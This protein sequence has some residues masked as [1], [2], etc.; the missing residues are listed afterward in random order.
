MN[1]KGN[2][3]SDFIKKAYDNGDI[4][5][6]SVAFNDFPPAQEWHHGKIDYFI[7][8]PSFYY[9]GKCEIG[10]IVFVREYTY[11]NGVQGRN[12]LFVIVDIDYIAVPIE[13]FDMLISSKLEKLKYGANLFI[14]KDNYNKLDKDSI[15]KTDA[16]YKLT[17]EQIIFKLGSVSIKKIKKYKNVYYEINNK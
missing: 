17:K 4:Y 15:I 8:E 10:D 11:G 2:G 14:K 7:N 16:I 6:V 1:K 13:Y 5:D 12:H 9:N 3:Y